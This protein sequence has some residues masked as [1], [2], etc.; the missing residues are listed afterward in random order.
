MSEVEHEILAVP[1]RK[2]V[3]VALIEIAKLL[4]KI[5]KEGITVNVDDTVFVE[6]VSGES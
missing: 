3:R 5:V 2:Q 1:E 6:K 4:E